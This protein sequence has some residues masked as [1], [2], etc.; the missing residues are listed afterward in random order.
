VHHRDA[1]GFQQLGDEVLIGRE[2]LAGWC[3]L[4][5]RARA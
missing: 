2:L 5:D 3:R 1:F 4:A